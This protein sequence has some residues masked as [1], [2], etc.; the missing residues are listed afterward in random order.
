MAALKARSY[1]DWQ[2]RMQLLAVADNL[3]MPTP[4]APAAAQPP[5]GR[6]S[7]DGGQKPSRASK[8]SLVIQG[9]QEPKKGK[10]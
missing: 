3:L 9:G 2:L 4:T 5:P 8:A 1:Q 7:L 6:P 10:L